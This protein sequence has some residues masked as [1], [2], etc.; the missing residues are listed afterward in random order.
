MVLFNW[1]TVLRHSNNSCLQIIQ[2]FEYITF[3]N[4]PENIYSVEY[5]YSLVD[6]RG[7]SFLLNP[8]PL[9][10]LRYGTRD[11][12]LDIAHY[13][14]LASLRNYSEFKATNKLSLDLLA[15][16]GK[17]DI[18]NKNR[19]LYIDNDVVRFKYEEAPQEN[20]IWH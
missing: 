3:R 17:E 11:Y 1:K 2:I 12:D 7:D 8:K 18:I 16:L 4:T 13:I 14:G 5:L 10:R 19:L 6:W 15:C 9:L 20:K